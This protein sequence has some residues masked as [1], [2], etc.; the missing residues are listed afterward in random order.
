M[1]RVLSAL[2]FAAAA[3]GESAGRLCI[4]ENN[5]I[6]CNAAQP[7][8]KVAPVAN[9]RQFLWTDSR[10]AEIAIGTIPAQATTV[11]VETLPRK[12][13]LSITP[14]DV[15]VTL[16]A[17]LDETTSWNWTLS[18]PAAIRAIR[19]PREIR[20]LV[21][22]AP[23]HR[24]V[25]FSIAVNA[26]N[27]LALGRAELERLDML[28]GRVVLAGGDTPLNTAAIETADGRFL[29][30]TD[31][32]GIFEV[33]IDGA[34]AA[35]WPAALHVRAS[36]YGT[37]ILPL[38]A[39]PQRRRWERVELTRGGS[40]EVS[41]NSEEEIALELRRH[42]GG[43]PDDWEIAG[44]AIAEESKAT[45]NDLDPGN[46]LLTCAGK[47]P[48]EQLAV[49]V[50]VRAAEVT[51]TSVE[52][53]R[54]P[55]RIS[56]KHGSTTI[57]DATIGIDFRNRWN[58]SV[59]APYEGVLWQRG[60]L[61]A[62][63]EIPERGVYPSRKSVEG[64]S[65]VDWT[66]TIPDRAIHGRVRDRSRLQPVANAVVV[67]DRDGNL[68]TARTDS[69]GA[70]RF[71]FLEPG[72]FSVRVLATERLLASA[73]QAN[74]GENDRARQVDF[75]LTAATLATV[76]FVTAA[77][78][79]AAN[80][81]VYD[82]SQPDVLFK[83]DEKGEIVLRLGEGETRRIIAVPW[84]GAF[85]VVNVT[86]RNDATEPVIVPFAEGPVQ[87]TVSA[88]DEGGQPIGGVWFQL[89]YNG[90]DLPTEVV[91]WIAA[92]DGNQLATG[93]DGVAVLSGMPLGVYDLW[94]VTTPRQARAEM[95][96]SRAPVRFSAQPGDNPV[97]LTFTRW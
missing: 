77:G 46:Y 3:L 70:Y 32:N 86:A 64:T 36:G 43:G 63:V 22:S 1:I 72:T 62:F 68:R 57:T 6:T 61:T 34:L 39:I 14:I 73:S 48:L 50:T 38:A 26:G 95:P 49:E 24:P 13:L 28:T 45:F 41:L 33:D 94:P 76:R 27:R 93:P 17:V 19:L 51:K 89:R 44:R 84:Q 16:K 66:V 65:D 15:P 88:K 21:I 31:P 58:A 90:H 96:T 75:E 81:K 83:T 37:K 85:T 97:K 55:I 23:R 35:N 56:V 40:V 67:L 87:M 18:N 79:P 25:T 59:R 11:D 53:E 91:Q 69:A 78:Q 20:G 12:A 29:G 7:T 54:V 52:I 5:A 80:A 42:R 10:G 60:M 92:R 8:F 30:N 82:E 47:G 74:L 4:A 2:L 9:V 71:E